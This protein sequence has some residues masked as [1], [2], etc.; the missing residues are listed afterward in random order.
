V[1]ATLW[2]TIGIGLG[3][4]IPYRYMGLTVRQT[5]GSTIVGMLWSS[6]SLQFVCMIK[7]EADSER[8]YMHRNLKILHV[9]INFAKMIAVLRLN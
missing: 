6:I 7:A 8:P 9:G 2:A 5:A 4:L 3:I 1:F